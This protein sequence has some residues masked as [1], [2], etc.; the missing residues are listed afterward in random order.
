MTEVEKFLKLKGDWTALHSRLN[1]IPSEISNLAG[2]LGPLQDAHT[3]A[4]I[5]GD[6]NAPNKKAEIDGMKTK[7]SGLEAEKKELTHRG[8]IMQEV[9]GEYRSKAAAELSQVHDKNFRAALKV[10]AAAIRAAHRAECELGAVYAKASAKFD[11]IDSQNPLPTWQA[12]FNRG[13]HDKSFISD[14]ENLFA[15]WTS[16]GFDVSEK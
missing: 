10:F 6:R 15:N 1:S 8:K 7:I 4:E 12:K 3:R 5:E 2:E 14:W 13:V 11:E 16:Q 9:L